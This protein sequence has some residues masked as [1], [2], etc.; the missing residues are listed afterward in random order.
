MHAVKGIFPGAFSRC[1][2]AMEF[3]FFFPEQIASHFACCL[4]QGLH[5]LGHKVNCNINPAEK[6]DSHGL[7]PPFSRMSANF[8][9]RT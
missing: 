9:N 1:R 8:V 7:A 3:T 5:Q 4:M 6:G 2:G